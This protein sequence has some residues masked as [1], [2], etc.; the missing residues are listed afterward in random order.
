MT[1][2]KYTVEHRNF[3]N[4]SSTWP[5][6]LKIWKGSLQNLK[7]VALK[8]DTSEQGYSPDP[9]SHGQKG[10]GSRL[11]LEVGMV[12]EGGQFLTPAHLIT[13]K[14]RM[15]VAEWNGCSNNGMC[16]WK[17]KL[18]LKL[19]VVLK[20]EHRGWGRS[21][22]FDDGFARLSQ[23][24]GHT[25]END[26]M[27]CNE[28]VHIP[29]HEG[30]EGN[31]ERFISKFCCQTEVDIHQGDAFNDDN[32]SLRWCTIAVARR[33]RETCTFQFPSHLHSR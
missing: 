15:K 26:H 13:T 22:K 8:Q 10:L 28:A 24:H 3:E 9:F 2:S 23:I 1:E 14:T 33:R 29:K 30:E 12:W 27:S 17:T 21:F 32:I 6:A 11:W 20:S 4:W 25:P 7:I 31:V 16:R 18:C 5:I 19:W